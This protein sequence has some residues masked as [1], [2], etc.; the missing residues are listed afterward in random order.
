MHSHFHQGRKGLP[1]QEDQEVYRSKDNEH[2]Y[3]VRDEGM[4]GLMIMEKTKNNF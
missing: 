1:H 4:R 2:K 3:K